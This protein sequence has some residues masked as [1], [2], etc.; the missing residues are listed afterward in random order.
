MR[1]RQVRAVITVEAAVVMGIVLLGLSLLLRMSLYLHDKAVLS[2]MALESAQAARERDRAE[3]GGEISEY[4]YSRIGG[5]LLYFSR[6]S[7][8]LSQN[9]KKVTVIAQAETGR[10]R[11]LATASAP[12]TIPEE[13]IRECRK[14]EE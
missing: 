14:G 7:F 10:T 5:K 4:F 12:L 3:E 9:E 8:T 1:S 6:P 2:G 11:I 13:K